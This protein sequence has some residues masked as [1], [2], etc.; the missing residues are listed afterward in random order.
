MQCS[1]PLLGLV[2]VRSRWESFFHDAPYRRYTISTRS[3]L[4]I[5][6]VR[7]FHLLLVYSSFA[8]PVRFHPSSQSINIIIHMNAET[9]PFSETPS[10]RVP[11]QRYQLY[12]YW[13]ILSFTS[14]YGDNKTYTKAS[15]WFTL[16]LLH[17]GIGLF[18]CHFR[19][20]V[21]C[22]WLVAWNVSFPSFERTDLRILPMSIAW[23]GD[24][25]SSTVWKKTH[26]TKWPWHPVYYP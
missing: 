12:L 7:L 21:S 1:F 18:F 13:I 6:Q 17:I 11:L 19:S 16:S 5:F 25:N 23:N 20:S 24:T 9:P 26:A 8:M 3:Q 10:D 14:P 22:E 15:L 4:L 2:R